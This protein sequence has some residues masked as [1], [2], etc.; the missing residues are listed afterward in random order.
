[1]K[2][3][4]YTVHDWVAA[5]LYAGLQRLQQYPV[6]Q[7]CFAM[8]ASWQSP[9]LVLVGMLV[10]F[11]IVGRWLDNNQV[12]PVTHGGAQLY[13]FAGV[14]AIVLFPM[15]LRITGRFIVALHHKALVVHLPRGELSPGDLRRGL[16]DAISLC[17][18]HGISRLVMESYLLSNDR[19][20]EQA[21]WL[22]KKSC[23]AQGVAGEATVGPRKGL[24]WFQHQVYK[25]AV[26]Q[27]AALRDSRFEVDA[28]GRLIVRKIVLNFM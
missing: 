1:M 28:R 7:R 5:R 2:A 24:S 12:L 26:A 25:F 15:S 3:M 27:S 9:L 16:D 17:K 23:K 8:M 10:L 22:L 21:A 4:L 13:L 11:Y 20:A 14:V 18:Q 19:S 6:H